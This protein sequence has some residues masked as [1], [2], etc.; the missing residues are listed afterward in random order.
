MA[1]FSERGLLFSSIRQTPTLGIRRQPCQGPGSCEDCSFL[2]QRTGSSS[3]NSQSGQHHWPKGR[4]RKSLVLFPLPLPPG[5]FPDLG[6]LSTSQI[7]AF[8]RAAREHENKSSSLVG[9]RQFNHP[10]FG[11]QGGLLQE[12]IWMPQLN[13]GLSNRHTQGS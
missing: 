1:S 11:G 3:H 2:T 6:S 7:P 4:E 8:L 10:R 13:P 9:K 12:I 5:M